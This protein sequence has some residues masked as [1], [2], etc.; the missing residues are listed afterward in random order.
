MYM[1]SPGLGWTGG[2]TIP[3]QEP[4]F[5]QQACSGQVARPMDPSS[6]LICG[7]SAEVP[8]LQR[9]GCQTVGFQGSHHCLTDEGNQGIFHCCPPG[10]LAAEM[11]RAAG[12]AP[13]PVNGAIAPLVNGAIAPLVQTAAAG[14][15]MGI[16]SIL[17]GT[18]ALGVGGYFAWK[19][20]KD[21]QEEAEL[22]GY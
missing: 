10:I 5:S 9:I 14:I 2:F 11:A 22:E 7:R 1:P 19:W 8:Y 18:L 17:V 6:D 15:G 16:G 20:Y 3:G 13:P 21:R 4:R 12:T